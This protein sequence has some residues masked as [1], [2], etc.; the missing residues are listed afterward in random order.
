MENK[1]LL[2]RY[3]QVMDYHYQ[4]KKMKENKEKTIL[5]LTYDTKLYSC[6]LFPYIQLIYPSTL[7]FA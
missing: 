7:T 4:E 1:K 5:D 6:F 2:T 3:K